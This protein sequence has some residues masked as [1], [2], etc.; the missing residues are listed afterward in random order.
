MIGGAS[1]S[2]T[3][4][5]I[6]GFIQRG[7]VVARASYLDSIHDLG[8]LELE[9]DLQEPFVLADGVGDARL[10]AV[11]GSQKIPNLGLVVLFVN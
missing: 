11:P 5:S 10:N 7:P 9:P 8:E 3:E 1:Q 6:L 2:C 4:F